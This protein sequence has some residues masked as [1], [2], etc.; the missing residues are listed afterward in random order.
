V[1]KGQTGGGFSGFKIVGNHVP[2]NL[3]PVHVR[4]ESPSVISHQ[5]FTTANDDVI[6]P[7]LEVVGQLSR[8]YLIIAVQEIF[9]RVEPV[10]DLKVDPPGC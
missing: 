6:S 2:R 4:Q 7:L 3:V 1:G 5:A 8:V 9:P 10:K